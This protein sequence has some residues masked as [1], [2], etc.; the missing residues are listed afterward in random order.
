LRCHAKHNPPP[1]L[2]FRETP[3]FLPPRLS[4]PATSSR[5]I[6]W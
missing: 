6:G 3:R 2:L 4:G 1:D 5:C